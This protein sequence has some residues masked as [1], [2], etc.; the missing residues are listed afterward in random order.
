MR[1]HLDTT[2]SWPLQ[3]R[4]SETNYHCGNVRLNTDPPVYAHL[5]HCLCVMQA[6]KD[7]AHCEFIVRWKGE[8]RRE[9][10]PRFH[11]CPLD[12]SGAENDWTDYR[13]GRPH[14]EAD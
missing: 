10:P 4:A 14:P 5:L 2:I 1:G 12:L 3:V 8:G 9:M 11:R 6:G 13:G 7:A